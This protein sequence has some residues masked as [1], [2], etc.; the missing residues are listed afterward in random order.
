MHVCIAYL[1]EIFPNNKNI[2]HYLLLFLNDEYVSGISI[3]KLI[4]Q[5]PKKI[6]KEIV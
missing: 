4:L 1:Y 5:V 6:Q 3:L 2:N